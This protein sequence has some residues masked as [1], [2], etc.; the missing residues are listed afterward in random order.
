MMMKKTG[1]L[2]RQ[3]LHSLAAMSVLCAGGLFATG[4]AEAAAVQEA[5]VYNNKTID[6]AYNISADQFNAG[7][8]AGLFITTSDPKAQYGADVGTVDFN[9]AVNI[10]T[11][12][13]SALFIDGTKVFDGTLNFNND[14]TLKAAAGQY[15][16]YIQ[17]NRGTNASC[18]L[19]INPNGK[20]TV[21]ITGDIYP[22][23]SQGGTDRVVNLN[24]AN[25]QSYW[26]GDI[27]DEHLTEKK[28]NTNLKLSN[29]AVWYTG[30]DAYKINT[31]SDDIFTIKSDSGIIDI[32]HSQPGEARQNK[33][34]GRTFT[35]NDVDDDFSG[36][37]GTT[38]R[39]GSN[40]EAG[41]S[42]KIV[43]NGKAG[44]TGTDQYYIQIVAD[45]SIK[46]ADATID[47]ASKKIVLAQVDG[48][49]LTK[50]NTKFTGKTYEGAEIDAG[51]TI[52][53]LTPE[54]KYD[55]TSSGWIID[56]MKVGKGSSGEKGSALVMAE[57][58]A[59]NSMNIASA[60]RG[61]NNDL[62]RRMGD[63]R[64]SSDE[65]GAWVRMYGGENKVSRGQSTNMTYKAVQ[66]GYDK[67][68]TLKNGRLF[69]GFAVSHLDGDASGSG[70][71]G[72]INS[73][74]F[75]L[76][77]SYAGNRGHFADLIVKYGRVNS[78]F[79]TDKNGN[80]YD[81]D[82][83]SNGFSITT[84]YGYR[85]NLKDDFYIEP[86]AELT[87]SHIGSSDY[88][89]S[90]NG[91][92]GA[93]VYNDAF[94]SLIGRVGFTLGRQQEAGNIYAKLSLAHEFQGD[95]ATQASYGDVTRNY[96]TGGSDT[97]IEYGI[98]FNNQL[99]KGTNLYGE[100]ERTTG[101]I[102]KTKW[103]ANLGLRYSF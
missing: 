7:Q 19:N 66:G 95:I 63:L 10:E 43:L 76:Y 74:M 53:D 11:S 75:G 80:S 47:L 1:K 103:R 24:L 51:L 68:T 17:D 91:K 59:A 52:I 46:S 39:I 65:A 84:E 8:N 102:V 20:S 78:D 2:G 93:A 82:Y 101:S 99:S 16:I 22:E 42:D 23:I 86:Q 72:D 48:T 70:I 56:K 32:Y 55:D 15:A 57:A 21:R 27:D 36:A 81:S 58:G 5:D 79:N 97:W 12:T 34:S 89:M 83:G 44:I 90:L 3:V 35:V 98:G 31:E 30:K 13:A 62:L 9:G 26:A 41:W 88:T 92:E 38:F 85:Q 49:N 64:G 69:T 73:T 33:D 71:D 77:G 54:L 67:A 96:T 4:N 40:I 87:Y 14:L 60:W 37:N 94:K 50:D 61:E 6:T 28:L 45:P 100:I 18:T 29:G 25:E